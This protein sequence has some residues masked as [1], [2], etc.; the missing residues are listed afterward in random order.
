MI[1]ILGAVLLFT[2]FMFSQNLQDELI[3]AFKNGKQ[4]SVKMI[5]ASELKKKTARCKLAVFTGNYND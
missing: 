2:S 1:R 5:V 3:K 4:D